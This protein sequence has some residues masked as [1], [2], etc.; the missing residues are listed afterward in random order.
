MGKALEQMSMEELEET[1]PEA[2]DVIGRMEIDN[3]Q[4]RENETHFIRL[5]EAQETGKT[6]RNPHPKYFAFYEHWQKF[7][8]NDRDYQAD[9][10]RKTK[11]LLIF[12]KFTKKGLQPI[13]YYSPSQIGALYARMLEQTK[14]ILGQ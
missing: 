14:K 9:T 1:L 6:E 10:D 8:V 4:R 3:A 11:G 5:V 2:S 13:T 12:P 7:H